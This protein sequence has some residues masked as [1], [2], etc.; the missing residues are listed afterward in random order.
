MVVVVSWLACTDDV[1]PEP[2]DTSAPVEPVSCDDPSPEP[3]FSSRHAVIGVAATPDRAPWVHVD[4]LEAP[5]PYLW[6]ETG[7]IGACRLLEME[8]P[9]CDPDCAWPDTCLDTDVCGPFPGRLSAGDLQFD[10]L[11]GVGTVAVTDPD[12]GWYAPAAPERLPG[13][14]EVVTVEAAGGELPPFSAST[15]GV[16]P[17]VLVGT[18]AW[19]A[20][21]DL[22]LAWT[23]IDEGSRVRAYF[24]S[25]WA[26]RLTP[27]IV[28]CDGPDTGSLV[29]PAAL[30]DG[31]MQGSWSCGSCILR[32]V[33]S[34]YRADETDGVRFEVHA[35][36]PLVLNHRGR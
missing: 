7:R 13:P 21:V 29:V 12:G 18:P 28:E 27:E 32:H 19:E 36:Q 35:D 11:P 31:V 1:D 8:I 34:R 26:H 5:L 22:A 17:L 24:A 23:G 9:R 3:D 2:G 20:G 16:D 10:G 14:D 4:L 15:C 30:L 6:V 25:D 33:V